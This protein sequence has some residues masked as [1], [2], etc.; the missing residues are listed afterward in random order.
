MAQTLALVPPPDIVSAPVA[1]TEPQDVSV[2]SSS[3]VL[4][5]TSLF[6]GMVTPVPIVDISDATV[7]PG[8]DGVDDD[9]EDD[10]FYGDDY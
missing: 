6:A 10:V 2:C 4:A 1:T 8:T 5:A 9:V 7:Q 3:P